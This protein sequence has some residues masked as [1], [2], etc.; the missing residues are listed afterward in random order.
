MLYTGVLARTYYAF[1]GT[2]L[3][4]SFAFVTLPSIGSDD[5]SMVPGRYGL[6]AMGKVQFQSQVVG[7]IERFVQTVM[8]PGSRVVQRLDPYCLYDGGPVYGM[9]ALYVPKTKASA[10]RINDVQIAP[11]LNDASCGLVF[12]THRGSPV[13]RGDGWCI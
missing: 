3:Q 8:I 4:Q 2:M 7:W 12:V 11:P 6:G 5:P 10:M 1:E 13:E 9:L